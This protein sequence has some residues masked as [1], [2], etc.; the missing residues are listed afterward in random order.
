MTSAS[1]ALSVFAVIVGWALIALVLIIEGK[2]TRRIC[3]KKEIN[4]GFRLLVV[5]G[6]GGFMITC[7]LLYPLLQEYAD[8]MVVFWGTVPGILWA[9]RILPD[10]VLLMGIIVYFGGFVKILGYEALKFTDEEKKLI[11]QERNKEVAA[12][13]RLAKF[14]RLKTKPVEGGLSIR[15]FR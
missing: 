14:F 3:L 8:K 6:L 5:A 7:L 2:P 10:F 9:F 11:A 13:P 12:H 1:V 15:P 4:T